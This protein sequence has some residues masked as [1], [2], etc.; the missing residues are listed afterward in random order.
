LNGG[1]IVLCGDL[2]NGRTVHAGVELYKHFP[3]RLVFVAPDTLRMPVEI[4]ASLRDKGLEVIEETDLEKALSG[5]DV[6]YMTRIGVWVDTEFGREHLRKAG[7]EVDDNIKVIRFPRSVAESSLMQ[8]PRQFSL[9]ARRPGWDLEM[10]AAT[11]PLGGTEVCGH[12]GMLN[13]SMLQIPENLLVDHEICMQVYDYYQDFDFDEHDMALDVIKDLGPKS[14]LLRQKHTRVHLRDF[15][16]SRVL[17]T[18]GPDGKTL[19]PEKAAFEEFKRLQTN[20]QPEPLP[21]ESIAE[22]DRILATAE[23]EAEKLEQ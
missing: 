1:T 15:R 20:H 8:C 14:H 22:L 23:R 9:G 13:G 21:D 17:R 16:L 18:K 2:K 6:L 19:P 4:T 7:A 11:I 5:A 12:L 3:F 10:N